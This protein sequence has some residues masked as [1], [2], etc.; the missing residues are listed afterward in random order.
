M[1]PKVWLASYPKSGNTW[2]RLVIGALMRQV[3]QALDINRIPGDSGGAS[4]RKPFDE[5]T[6]LPSS[7]LTHDE[8]DALRP[9]VDADIDRRTLPSDG[10]AG[11]PDVRFVKLHD[12]YTA[13]PAPPAAAAVPLFA[14]ARGALLL[15]RDPR[16]VASS[17][18]NHNRSTIDRAIELMADSTAVLCGAG[19]PHE[20]LRQKLLGWSGHAA[21]W[22]D[23]RDLPVHV[24]R[25]EDMKRDTVGTALEAM[26]FAG[27]P[28]SRARMEAAVDIASFD[29]LREQEGTLGFAEWHDPD[30]RRFF[31]RGEAGGWRDELTLEQVDR[32]ERAHA[33]M[34]RRLG[35]E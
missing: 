28:V 20:Q 26:R 5:A 14:G 30:G 29:K 12:A 25:Y 35:Y 8:I 23:Q 1:N 31:R 18:A 24:M 27:W 33:P 3:G 16:D 10:V 22:L 6:L 4:A 9:A 34:M 21:S 32:I 11:A 19:R 13:T 17:Y 7:L 2:M 15:V